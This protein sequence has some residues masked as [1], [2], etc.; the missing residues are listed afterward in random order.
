MNLIKSKVA[1]SVREKSVAVY[2]SAF[3]AAPLVVFNHF[4]GDGEEIAESIAALGCESSLLVVSALD[5]NRDMSPWESPPVMK[6]DAPYLG[7]ASDYLSLL[8][9]EIMPQAMRVI[10]GSPAFSAIAGYSLAGLFSLYSLYNCGVFSRAA[11]VSGSLWFPGFE[12]YITEHDFMRKPQRIYLSLGD[13]EAHVNNPVISSVR[14]KTERIAGLFCSRGVDTLFELNPGN[15]FK[16]AEKR[17]VRAV[18]ALLK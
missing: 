4:T 18:A 16:D 3:E 10:G 14:E 8:T 15:H 6:N 7:G 17:C 13:R 12:E 2:P 9:G 1:F 5:W 11:S